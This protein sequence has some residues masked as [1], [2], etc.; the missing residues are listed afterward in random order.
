MLL[1]GRDLTYIADFKSQLSARF[2]IKDLGEVK[3]ILGMRVTRNRADRTLT[4]GQSDY[5]RKLVRKYRLD[6][7]ANYNAKIPITKSFVNTVIDADAP[8]ISESFPYRNAVGAVLYCN[9]CTR[10]DISYAVSALASHNSDP[11]RPH[12]NGV[13]GLLKYISDT[14]DLAITYGRNISGGTNQIK[15]YADADFSKDPGKR[16]S[17]SGFVIYMNGGPIAWNSSLQKTLSMSTTES[18]MYAMYDAVI[19]A[20]WFKEFLE[21]IGF[22]QDTITCLEDNSGL[23]DWINNQRS[24][25]R[26]KAIPRHYYKLREYKNDNICR[27]VHVISQLQTAD[28]LTKQLEY[29]LFSTLLKLLYNI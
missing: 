18:E 24:S 11:K 8:N 7:D 1:F 2:N 12:W 29:P 22:Q 17:R 28:I 15:V 9:T 27:F 14:Q 16:R 26:M 10:P 19:Q 4:L 6:P 13:M 20:L 5:I 25:S 21:E 3:D 23:L